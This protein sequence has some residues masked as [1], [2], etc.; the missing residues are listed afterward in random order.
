L[1]VS[2]FDKEK[3]RSEIRGKKRELNEI[4][5]EYSRHEGQSREKRA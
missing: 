4:K 3:L 5:S 2:Q 1:P